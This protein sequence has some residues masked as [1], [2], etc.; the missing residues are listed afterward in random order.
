M[1]DSQSTVRNFVCCNYQNFGANGDFYKFVNSS[2]FQHG[3]ERFS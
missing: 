1:Q 3:V 2:S